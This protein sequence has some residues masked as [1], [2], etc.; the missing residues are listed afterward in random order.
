M[1]SGER[2][3]AESVVVNRITPNNMLRSIISSRI[4]ESGGRSQGVV[5]MASCIEASEP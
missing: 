3:T 1:V 2:N 5:V 4:I